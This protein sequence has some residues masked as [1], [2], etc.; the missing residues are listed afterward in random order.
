MIVLAITI[1]IATRSNHQTY[2]VGKSVLRNFS[3][4]AGKHLC[5]VPFY[6]KVAGLRACNLIKKETLAP[7]FSYE[8][9]EISK[10]TF[11]QNTSERL[12][13]DN[14]ALRS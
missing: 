4:F 11:S 10:N 5:Q 9:C 13:L 12:L 1:Q 2:S 6:N 14:T 3:K 7:V 8:F